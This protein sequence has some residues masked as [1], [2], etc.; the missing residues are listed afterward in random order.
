MKKTIILKPEWGT[1]AV[2]KVLDNKTVIRNLGRF[3]R[4]NLETIWH[5]PQYVT[6]RDELLQ[7]MINF[8]LCYQIPGTGDYLA[9]QLLS[10]NQPDYGWPESN[11]LILRYTYDFMPKGILT[12]LIVAMHRWIADQRYIWKS[13]VILRKDRTAA[14][15]VEYYDQREI[16]IRIAGRHK[17]ELLTIVT[18]ELDKI[19]GS[20]RRLKYDQLIPCNCAACKDSQDPHFY[21]FEVLQK[22]TEDQQESIQCQKSYDMV[23]VWGLIDDVLDKRRMFGDERDEGVGKLIRTYERRLEI[24]EGKQ[25]EYGLNVPA[26]IVMEIED[27]K[28][29]LRKLRR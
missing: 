12:Q 21:P 13:G 10:A 2:Y 19:H 15:V 14:E 25:A 28:A 27:I 9:P 26:E 16:K 29:E 1:A 11:N 3:S 23:S 22:F 24:L 6:M 17:K 7:L 5:E 18:Y 8:K 20:Y 4:D